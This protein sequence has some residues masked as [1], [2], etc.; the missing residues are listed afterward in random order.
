MAKNLFRF[1]NLRTFGNF[2]AVD[3]V[4][5]DI[6]K[7]EIFGLLGPNRWEKQQRVRMLCGILKP[8]SGE[9][10]FSVMMWQK[11]QE[12]VKKRIGY[13]SQK[14][15]LYN[16]LTVAENLNFYADL[17][18]IPQETMRRLGKSN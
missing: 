14:F 5:F 12:K 11:N 17:Y 1:L 9:T 3:H 18:G 10:K 2:V 7:G 15:S 6:P 4:S 8:T 16:D 13:M